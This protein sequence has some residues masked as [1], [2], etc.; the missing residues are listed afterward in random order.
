MQINNSRLLVTLEIA[1]LI[2]FPLNFGA[3]MSPKRRTLLQLVS[4][5]YVYLNRC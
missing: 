5:V 2:W 4:P 1:Y 3:K